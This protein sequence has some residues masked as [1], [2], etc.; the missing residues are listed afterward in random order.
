M[1]ENSSAPLVPDTSHV[2]LVHPV[3]LGDLGIRDDPDGKQAQTLLT[4]LREAL[5]GGDLDQ[6]WALI[7]GS[8]LPLPKLL[9]ALARPDTRARRVRV[10]LVASTSDGPR[11]S[12]CDVPDLC[13]TLNAALTE[14]RPRIHEETGRAFEILDVSC[15]FPDGLGE[16]DIE[17]ELAQQHEALG[18]DA[19][20]RVLISWGSGA[21]STSF[22]AASAAVRLRL[23]WWFLDYISTDP[24][25][26]SAPASGQAAASAADPLDA[27]DRTIPP[28]VPYLVRMRLFHELAQLAGDDPQVRLTEE[29]ERAVSDMVKLVDR[30]YRAEDAEALRQVAWEALVR[31]DG[32]AGFALRRYV[33]ERYYEMCDN[34]GVPRAEIPQKRKKKESGIPRLGP[35]CERAAT[36]IDTDPAHRPNLWLASDQVRTVN[37]FGS[38]AHDLALS[39]P[40]QT[41]NIARW[42]TR[43][44]GLS[45]AEADLISQLR[46][47]P[48]TGPATGLLAVWAVGLGRPEDE[49]VTVAHHLLHQGPGDMVTQFLGSNQFPMRALLLATDESRP[50]A[51]RQREELCSAGSRDVRATVQTVGPDFH[52]RDRVRPQ[53]RVYLSEILAKDGDAIGGLL[54]VPTGPKPVVMAALQELFKISAERALPLFVQDMAAPGSALG[55]LHLW[56]AA[57]GHDRPLLTTALGALDRLELDAAARLLAGTTRAED[58]AVECAALAR[59]FTGRGE[60]WQNWPHS[61]SD[62]PDIAP[63]DRW[64]KRGRLAQRL[65]LI[66]HCA[67]TLDSQTDQGRNM[68]LTRFLVLASTMVENWKPLLDPPGSGNKWGRLEEVAKRPTKKHP[69]PISPAKSHAAVLVALRTARNKIPIT[70]NYANDAKKAVDAT[71]MNLGIDVNSLKKPWPE[72]VT[73]RTLLQT[74]PEAAQP[75]DLPADSGGTLLDR[76]RCLRK[77]VVRACQDAGAE[78]RP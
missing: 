74:A 28:A 70:H 44:D 35:L 39:D 77:R 49:R 76:F 32:T 69:G 4:Q 13:R 41:G 16:C 26:G 24:I 59:A 15:A 14:L 61:V 2:W 47:H 62:V 53:I 17:P 56:P 1:P 21:T 37:D 68:L 42:M 43:W 57:I 60:D 34:L 20:G 33:I 12:G 3:G 46:I 8:Q 31:W 52:D 45:L 65:A 18:A 67:S 25:S 38:A 9:R 27:V 7:W 55:K 50:H 64:V 58:L 36:L 22:G 11:N 19:P 30:G 51:E 72:T 10:L 73:A 23:P 48:S 66:A 29:Q 71:V 78:V 40:H 5:A 63:A 54:L 75:W 6:L